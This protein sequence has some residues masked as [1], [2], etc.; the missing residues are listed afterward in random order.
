M[1]PDQVSGYQFKRRNKVLRFE[2]D[3]KEYEEKKKLRRA[4]DSVKS[5]KFGKAKQHGLEKKSPSS[6]AEKG[7]TPRQNP[8]V[9][10]MEKNLG[11]RTIETV[12][13]YLKWKHPYVDDEAES[14]D[15]DF[16]LADFVRNAQSPAIWKDYDTSKGQSAMMNH[17]LPSRMSLVLTVHEVEVLSNCLQY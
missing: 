14:N 7:G 8:R 13:D 4:A 3:S 10:C 9:S 1:V 6:V 12:A 11:K 15:D 5:T 17:C 16:V 2:R